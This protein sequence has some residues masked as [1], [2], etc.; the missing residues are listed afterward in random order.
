ML[1]SLE[2]TNRATK[3]TAIIGIQPLS[4]SLGMELTPEVAARVP[5]LLAMTLTEL[6]ALGITAEARH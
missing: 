1:A 6:Q 3:S 4:M 2:F 5:E